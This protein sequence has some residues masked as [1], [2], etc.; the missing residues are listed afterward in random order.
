MT[1]KVSHI[2]HI[3]NL[4]SILTQGG[5]WSDHKRLELGLVNQNIGYSHIKQCRLVRLV[6]VAA[7]GT[8]GQ[9]VPFN[10]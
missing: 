1:V 8:I 9:Y 6:N 5:L 10:F 7:G 3:D 2:T 4:F